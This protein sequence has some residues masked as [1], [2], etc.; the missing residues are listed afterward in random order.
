[1]KKEL[2]FALFVFL[3]TTVISILIY[4]VFYIIVAAGIS[5]FIPNFVV[6]LA[7]AIFGTLMIT[8][9]KKVDLNLISPKTYFLNMLLILAIYH[10][11][12]ILIFKFSDFSS[13]TAGGTMAS[14]SAWG[15]IL[16]SITARIAFDLIYIVIAFYIVRATMRKSL[17]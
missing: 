9:L 5:F 1:M 8:R 10:I 15:S 17:R 6:A 12:Y 7:S 2:S 4:T 3:T 13:A 16:G 14:Y 11:L